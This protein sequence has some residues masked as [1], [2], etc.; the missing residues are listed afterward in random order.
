MLEPAAHL[1][2]KKR[3]KRNK[4]NQRKSNALTDREERD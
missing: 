4:K 3:N 1:Y 2:E